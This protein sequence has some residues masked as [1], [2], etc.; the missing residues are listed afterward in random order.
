M[1]ASESN[2]A[3]S[4]STL[5]SSVTLPGS[6]A[7]LVECSE[8]EQ[9]ASHSVEMAAT[10]SHARMAQRVRQVVALRSSRGARSGSDDRLSRM[11]H[12]EQTND[13]DGRLPVDVRLRSLRGAITAARRR[14]LRVLFLLRSALPAHAGRQPVLLRL[15]ARSRGPASKPADAH[16]PVSEPYGDALSAAFSRCRRNRSR[17]S[18]NERNPRPQ[19]PRHRSPGRSSRAAERSCPSF[20]RCW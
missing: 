4:V 19:Q 13:A 1:P 17:P 10:T 7:M 14:L 6:E 5:L 11:R 16:R 12:A 3:R 20:P 8:P 18:P 2:A 9:P 15:G